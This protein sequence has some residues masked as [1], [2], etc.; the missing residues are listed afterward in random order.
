LRSRSWP[1]LDPGHEQVYD[2]SDARRTQVWPPGRGIDPAE[3]GLAVELRQRVEV[4]PGRIGLQRGGG[5]VGKIAALRA[6][7]RQFTSISSPTATPAPCIQIGVT[8]N[9]HLLPPG[10]MV[11][12]TYL[13]SIVPPTWCSA[14]APHVWSGSNGIAMTA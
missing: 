9:A 6:F 3:A 1:L 12:R 7:R 10:A 5:V 13:P 8:V 14:L 4:R 2:I 11:P